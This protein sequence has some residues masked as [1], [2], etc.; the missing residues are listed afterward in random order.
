MS[1]GVITQWKN[2]DDLFSMLDAESSPPVAD[3]QLSSAERRRRRAG[4]ERR[5]AAREGVSQHKV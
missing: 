1:P 2:V 3:V 4:D 5:V